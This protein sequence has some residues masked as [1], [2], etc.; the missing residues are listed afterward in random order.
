MDFSDF[1][2]EFTKNAKRIFKDNQKLF[3]ADIDKNLLWETY[4][5]SFPLE[6]N[7]LYRTRREFDCSCCKNFIRSFGNVV[8]I[9]GNK[10]I[11]FWDFHTD[12]D[13]F[14]PVLV[15]MSKLVRDTVVSDIF[16]TKQNVFGAEKTLELLENQTVHPWNHFYVEVPKTFVND[17][18]HLSV[19]EIMSTS[20]DIRNVFKRSL[21]EI[22]TSSVEEVLDLISEGML[23]RGE[24]WKTVLEKFLSLQKEYKKLKTTQ[25]K[26]NYCWLTSV[27]VGGS[28]SKIRN[29]SIGTLLTDISNGVEIEQAV[30]KYESIIAPTNYKRP[31]AI[32]TAK[33]IDEA[34]K[35]I[36]RLGFLNS[37][38]RRH[39]KISDLTIN[40]VI[41]ANRN[42]KKSMTGGD[43]VFKSLKEELPINPKTFEKATGIGV[44]EFLSQLDGVKVLEVL[45]EN[46]HSGNLFSLIASQDKN[47]PSM[48]KWNN[49]FSWSY[50]GNIAD[51]M[52]QRVKSAGGKVDGILR[53]SL[54]WNT[55]GDNLNDYDAHCIEPDG[56]EIYFRSKGTHHR[57]GGI[58]D[59][60]IINP[61]RN[62]VA[63]ENI[64]W[65]TTS[66]MKAGKYIFFVHNYSHRGGDSGFDAEIEIDGQIHE[67]SYH[68]NIAQGEKVIVA[69][70]TL[71]KFGDFSIGNSLASSISS[72]TIW[73]MK[74][75]QF[76]PV[77]TVMFSPNYWDGQEGVGNK[78]HFFVLSGCNNDTKPNGFYNE[79][80]KEDLM[81]HKK[82]FEALG[83][84]MKVEDSDVQLSGL[85]FSSTQRDYVIVRIDG[86]IKKVIF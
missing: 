77:S 1:M 78:H 39:A 9:E 45:F 66:N 14:E 55:N 71:G 33:M 51:S 30:R 80:L 57:S 47:A 42:A 36:E 69:E 5:E 23:Y 48:F 12:D 56:N 68:K 52:K 34:E 58:L 38:G 63:V 70:V 62:Q 44:S 29:H 67:F 54:Q 81:K 3:Y 64:T 35:T 49:G 85:G 37:L 2:K 15:A 13:T 16:V 61:L 25:Q 75:N 41:W 72:K 28:V 46:R 24:E 17:A 43:S 86:K 27:S 11:T 26:E 10:I 31:K 84:K 76:V 8:A 21:E 74:T 50:N 82:V 65:A 32:F 79:Y 73:S 22:S 20:R 83:N 18:S 40:N 6:K 19:N 59:V 4:L 53:F 7:Q 60:D